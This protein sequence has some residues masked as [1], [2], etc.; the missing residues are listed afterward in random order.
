MSTLKDILKDKVFA[1]TR[2]KAEKFERALDQIVVAEDAEAMRTIAKAAVQREEETDETRLEYWRKAEAVG[3]RR[4][5]E[6]GA[7]IRRIEKLIRRKQGKQAAAPTV[8]RS[9]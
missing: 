2:D 8:G 7:Q 5:A 1:E 3:L 4:L 9:R 6:Y